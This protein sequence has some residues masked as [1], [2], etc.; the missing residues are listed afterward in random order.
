MSA[1]TL[2]TLKADFEAAR[3]ALMAAVQAN[4]DDHLRISNGHMPYVPLN[5]LRQAA[6]WTADDFAAQT[7]RK[8]KDALQ[9]AVVLA[10]RAY[11]DARDGGE[12]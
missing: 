10:A 11:V 5:W 1:V 2:E 12:A 8:R 3:D 6:R 7:F 9:K 4:V